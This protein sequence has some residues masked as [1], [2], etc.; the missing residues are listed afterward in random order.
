MQRVSWGK[1]CIYKV[2]ELIPY[3]GLKHL[4]ENGGVPDYFLVSIVCFLFFVGLGCTYFYLDEQLLVGRVFAYSLFNQYRYVFNNRGWVVEFGVDVYMVSC[5]SC[6]S[7]LISRKFVDLRLG[8]V[9]TL[10]T[11]SLCITIIFPLYIYIYK[12][13]ICHCVACH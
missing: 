7:R 11:I 10:N 9:S 6:I 2:E 3:V 5:L 13:R 12:S 8:V 1:M 4:I